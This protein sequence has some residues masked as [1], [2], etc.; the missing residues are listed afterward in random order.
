MVETTSEFWRR[1]LLFRDYL[2]V[3][4]EDARAYETLKRHLASRFD[5]GRHY[6]AA[7]SVFI[8]TILDKIDRAST[9]TKN[10]QPGL[11]CPWTHKTPSEFWRRQPLFRDYLRAHPIDEPERRG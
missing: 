4:P 2:R 1:Q 3:H 9:L 8:K 6:A 7:E 10:S 11:A 5:V